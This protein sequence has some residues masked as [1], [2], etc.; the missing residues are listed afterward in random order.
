MSGRRHREAAVHP[1][2]LRLAEMLGPAAGDLDALRRLA[3]LAGATVRQARDAAKGRS[4]AADAFLGLAWAVGL[5]PASGRAQFPCA[6]SARP[7]RVLWWLVRGNLALA[8]AAR[9]L[10]LRAAAAEIGIGHVTLDRAE[11]GVPV[12]ADTLLLVAAWLGMPPRWLTDA[13]PCF[14]VGPARRRRAAPAVPPPVSRETA[15]RAPIVAEVA[16]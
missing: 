6:P 12:S 13:A 7:G 14:R 10:S 8:R 2:R 11:T 1:A 3:D 15:G 4:V 5:D 9:G 16:P